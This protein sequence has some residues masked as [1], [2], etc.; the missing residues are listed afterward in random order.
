MDWHRKDYPAG[1]CA[2]KVLGNQKGDYALYKK[3]M[4]EQIAEL[5]DSYRP[6]NIWFDGEWEHAHHKDGK[7]VRS[8]DWEFDDIFD[9]I[10]SKH[11]LVANNNHQPIRPKEDIQ[12]FERDL[13]GTT[14]TAGSRRTSRS[15]RTVRSSSAT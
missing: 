6:G 15:F 3:F 14:A 9:L 1:G 11:V 7:W 12:L 13:P 8:L 4:M 2:K 10:H 5:I